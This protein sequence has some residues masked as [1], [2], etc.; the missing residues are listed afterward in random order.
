MIR[1]RNPGTN[2]NHVI[3][4][5][6]SI[7]EIYKYDPVSLNDLKDQSAKLGVITSHGYAGSKALLANKD[8]EKS[9]DGIYN[10]MKMYSEIFRLLGVLTPA[11]PNKS[12]PFLF[13]F[14]GQ[15]LAMA[16]DPLP[17]M[18]E[19]FWGMCNPN[20]LTT[21]ISYTEEVRFLK[22]TLRMMLDLGGT[23]YKH[24]LCLG[25][26]SVN[27]TNEKEYQDMICKIKEIRGSKERLTNAV[28]Q[29][30]DT[31]GMTVEAIDNCT[32]TPIGLMKYC[33]Y[34]EDVFTSRL[35][36]HKMKCLRITPKGIAAYKKYSR[37]K[38][39]RLN[40]FEMVNEE[41]QNSLIRLGIYSM[42]KRAGFNM[43]SVESEMEYDKDILSNILQGRELLFS[44]CAVLREN[45][46][47]EVDDFRRDKNIHINIKRVANDPA[48]LYSTNDKKKKLLK[49]NILA[50]RDDIVL[51]DDVDI[52]FLNEVE[53]Y[54]K[55]GCSKKE[56]VDIIFQNHYLDKKDVFYPLISTLFKIIGFDCITSR[57]GDNGSRYDAVIRDASRSIPIEIKSPTEED[58]VNLKAIRQA[59][60]NK[61]IMLS[62][63]QER[64]PTN[65]SISSLAVGY[66][67]P[68]DRS[69]IQN[70]IE[71][72]RD[73]YGIK[74]GVIGFKSLIILAILSL[75]DK[76]TI[77]KNQIFGME[78]IVDANI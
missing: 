75:M 65:I 12:N 26:M 4:I 42:L 38:D 2:Y 10:N 41:K 59:L 53:K 45:R 3:H 20:Q 49:A 31:L 74:I 32:R 7:Y 24:E 9:K 39:I 55:K 19:C 69:D 11:Y 72:I 17:L 56:I 5:I 14:I 78:G 43:D 48:G 70:M 63:D 6:R 22:C 21:K 30:G 44:P 71:A 46:I 27:D 29:L 8:K 77:D 15:H 1:F 13:T 73:T 66:N 23:I 35:Y 58:V 18:E 57:D 68:N 54:K 25:S 60:E 28:S 16:S 52:E 67:L 62:R 50:N 47:A 36:N 61:I 33:G 51:N 37:M 34:V 64:Y 40:D 76:K